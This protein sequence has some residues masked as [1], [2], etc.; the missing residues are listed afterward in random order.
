MK[1]ALGETEGHLMEQTYLN[2]GR[3][4]R[5]RDGGRSKTRFDGC[6]HCFIGR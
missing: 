6:A 5:G 4:Y 3:R 1:L 2:A